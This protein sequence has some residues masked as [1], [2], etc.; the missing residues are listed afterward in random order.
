MCLRVVVVKNQWANSPQLPSL[1]PH[2][3]NMHFQHLHVEC[4]INTGL[5]GHRFKVDDTA[6]IEKSRSTLFW[7]LHFDVHGFPGLG[8]HHKLFLISLT[9][10]L[11]ISTV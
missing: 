9:F 5:F 7:V 4:L 11:A 10:R 8:I 3:I 6:D 2:G 1:A